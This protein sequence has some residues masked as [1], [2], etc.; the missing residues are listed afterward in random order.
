VQVQIDQMR[1]LVTALC[2]QP[3]LTDVVVLWSPG[4][5]H[6][7]QDFEYGKGHCRACSRAPPPVVPNHY[8]SR[9][10]IDPLRERRCGDYAEQI[11][12]LERT[13]DNIAVFTG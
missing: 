7:L 5:A 4:P 12:A 9:G 2:K 10:Q 6:H 13:F 8:R 1:L 3:R 11:T